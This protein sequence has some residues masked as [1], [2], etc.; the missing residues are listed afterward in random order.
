MNKIIL[1]LFVSLIIMASS[2]FGEDE[3]RILGLWNTSGNPTIEIF[4]CGE[5]YCGKIAKLERPNYPADDEGGMAGQP[6]VDLNNPDPNLRTRPLLGMQ[7]CEGF[8][9]SGGDVW[10]SGRIYDAGSGKIYKCKMTLTDPNRLEVR[11]YIGFSLLGRTEI[12]I[13]SDGAS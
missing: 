6:R 2:A 4:R 3:D 12:W 13:R 1:A 10:K 5:N 8:T 7:L 9:Y 11:G